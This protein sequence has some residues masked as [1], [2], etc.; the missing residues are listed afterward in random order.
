M[1]KY[2]FLQ[3]QMIDK[4]L[5]CMGNEVIIGNDDIKWSHDPGLLVPK[6]GSDLEGYTKVVVSERQELHDVS[7]KKWL[8]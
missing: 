8:C 1:A 3:E 7:I 4:I 2:I 6:D 5:L